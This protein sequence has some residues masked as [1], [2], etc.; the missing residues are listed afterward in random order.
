MDEEDDDDDDGETRARPASPPPPLLDIA[1]VRVDGTRENLTS[2]VGDDTP[3]SKTKAIRGVLYV[4]P[5]SA[6]VRNVLAVSPLTPTSATMPSSSHAA[7]MSSLRAA[8]DASR[9]RILDLEGELH[10][11]RNACHCCT[12]VAL[13]FVVL[14]VCIIAVLVNNDG[15]LAP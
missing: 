6:R 8:I 14:L 10:A 12:L 2:R 7:E 9:I 13:I 11:S 15:V 1:L 4:S 5:V 3:P